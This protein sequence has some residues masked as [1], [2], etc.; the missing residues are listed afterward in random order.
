MTGALSILIFSGLLTV[1]VID[2]PFAGGVKVEPNALVYVL[3][4]IAGVT[5]Q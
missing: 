4:D 3:R 5:L 2:R 1:V